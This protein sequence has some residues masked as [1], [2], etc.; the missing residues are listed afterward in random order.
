MFF[1]L[2]LVLCGGTVEAYLPVIMMHGFTFSNK[3]GNHHD[4]DHIVSWINKY[5][6]G[7]KTLALSLFEGEASGTPMFEQLPNITAAIQSAVQQWGASKFHIIG[8]RFSRFL[9]L[10]VLPL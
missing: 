7:T 6:P 2:L 8:L 3:D 5:H 10:L 4:F 1:V 9:L